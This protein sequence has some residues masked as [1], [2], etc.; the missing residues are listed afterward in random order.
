MPLVWVPIHSLVGE[1]VSVPCIASPSSSELQ[2]C[3]GLP[4]AQMVENLPAVQE[5]WVSPLGREDPLE[6]D[7]TTQSSILAWR[8]PWTNEPGGL[9]SMRLQR[10]RHD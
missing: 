9:P 7:K 2:H 3:W 10:V 1:S 6:K 4:V 5:T 8:I